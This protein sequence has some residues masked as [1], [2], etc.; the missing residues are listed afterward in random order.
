[1]Q[2]RAYIV[3]CCAVIFAL[4]IATPFSNSDARPAERASI[5]QPK[6]VVVIAIDQGRYDYLQRFRREFVAGGFNLLLSGASFTDCR[7]DYATTV[8]GP[9]HAT[10]FTGAYPDMHGIIEN[11]WYDRAAHK[12]VYCV[13]DSSTKEVDA[14]NGAGGPGASPRRLM[15][16]TLGDEL[17]MASDFKSKV[18]AI[19]LKDRSA[20]L[21]GGH[22]ASAAYWWDEKDGHFVTSTYYAQDLPAWVERFNAAAPAKPYCGKEWRA[23]A[24]TPGARGKILSAFRSSANEECPDTRFTEWLHGTPYMNEI[25]LKFAEAAI[26]SEHLGRGPATDLLAISLSVNDV[27]G[28]G[29]GPYSAEVADVTLRTDRYLADFLRQLDRLVGLRNVWIALSADHGVAP[30]PGYIN[31]HRLGVGNG[32]FLEDVKAAVERALT[33]AFGEGP[34]V[35]G[36]TEFG[37]YFNRTTIAQHRADEA[38]VE[39]TAAEAAVDVPGIREA[40]T[41]TQLMTGALPRSPLARKASNSFNNQR[42]GDVF[43]IRDPF[44]VPV[45]GTRGTT[46]GSPWNYDAQVPLVFWGSA[47]KAGVYATPCQPTDLTATL[48]V[49]LGLTQP[50]DTEGHPLSVALK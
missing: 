41:R 13:E 44:A 30:D 35:E 46:H 19:S 32:A 4:L 16:T 6:L 45:K 15:G 48:A 42:S 5:T 39:S 29:Y 47:F 10:L 28:H 25:E 11:T 2:K 12:P 14:P 36:V 43:L 33:Q 24:D 7:Y 37:L 23:L 34:W 9:G 3:S 26:G 49:A 22:D 50:S 27:I 1:M 20:V 38:K 40:F 21:P 31:E 8:T 17:R 18:I